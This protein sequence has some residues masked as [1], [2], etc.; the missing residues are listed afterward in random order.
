MLRFSRFLLDPTPL[1][2]TVK[3]R[4][5]AR[6]E[7]RSTIIITSSINKFKSNEEARPTTSLTSSI[8]HS[9]GFA[10]EGGRSRSA[11]EVRQVL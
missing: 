3:F 11:S 10:T 4:M 8:L 2:L 6:A 1:P 5:K 7:L 9:R